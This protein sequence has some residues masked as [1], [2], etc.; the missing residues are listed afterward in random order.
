MTEIEEIKKKFYK[1]LTQKPTED[2]TADLR[3]YTQMATYNAD[4]VWNF[5]EPYL[6]PRNEVIELL[7]KELRWHQN[8]DNKSMGVTDDQKKWFCEGIIQS[9]YLVMGD[10]GKKSFEQ[11][12][13]ALK[14]NESKEGK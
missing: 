2:F 7:T 11:L 8:A 1:E 14:T 13:E 9:I 3:G 5:F 10:S 12:K 4:V 6:K